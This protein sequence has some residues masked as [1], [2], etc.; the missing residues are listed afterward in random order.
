MTIASVEPQ[1]I[2][3]GGTEGVV[4]AVEATAICPGVQVWRV[5]IA[6][7]ATTPVMRIKAMGHDDGEAPDA[8]ARDGEFVAE[9]V[10]PFG[11][12][13]P[14]QTLTVRAATVINGVAVEATT[15]M[16]LEEP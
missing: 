9:L 13:V 6:I 8:T 7:V 10:N 16:E 14:A 15:P 11:V 12:G 4:V 5:E 3:R 2:S 1:A